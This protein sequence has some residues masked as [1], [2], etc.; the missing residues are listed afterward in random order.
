MGYPHSWMVYTVK[1]HLDMDD[2]W[3]YPPIY[4]DLR[5]IISSWH[6]DTTHRPLSGTLLQG[7]RGIPRS[8]CEARHWLWSPAA[9]H[10]FYLGL[11]SCITYMIMIYNVY[12]IQYRVHSNLHGTN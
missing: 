8:R 3:G 5:I 2:D 12:Y 6:S 9:F 11:Q 10:G 1:Y 4:G 7:Q